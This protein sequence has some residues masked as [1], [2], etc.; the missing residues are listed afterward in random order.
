MCYRTHRH[1]SAGSFTAKLGPEPFGVK[2]GVW[3]EKR[4]LMATM[5]NEDDLTAAAGE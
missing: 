2:Y 4:D 1:S 5:F 3:V